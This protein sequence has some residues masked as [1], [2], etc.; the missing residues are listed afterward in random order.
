MIP[1]AKL[2]THQKELVEAARAARRNAYA[3]Y[4][5]F[6]VGAA[7]RARNGDMFSGCNVENISF[8]AGICAERGA[9]LHAVSQGLRSGQ[10]QAV[11]VYT[12]ASQVTPP[13]G[14]CLQVLQEFGRNP[15]IL[16]ANA[17]GVR[18]VTLADLLPIPFTPYE[19]VPE[20]ERTSSPMN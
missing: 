6:K 13:C 18:V 20:I 3:P 4:S 11:A 10:L 16:L 14:M 9:I 15:E 17:K 19:G 2:Q 12:R 1:I 7:V 5:G 8:G